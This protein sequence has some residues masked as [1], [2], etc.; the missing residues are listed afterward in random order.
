MVNRTTTI[1]NP[2][3]L[4]GFQGSAWFYPIA[5]ILALLGLG[6][7]VPS[8]ILREGALVALLGVV[9]L[10]LATNLIFSRVPQA[11][12]D[13]TFGDFVAIAL[14]V[15]VLTSV[16]WFRAAIV[17]CRRASEP[18]SCVAG[19]FGKGS[20]QRPVRPGPIP[21]RGLSR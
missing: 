11:N 16:Y 13:R 3:R 19:R 8:A 14:V 2:A 6:S 15:V 18:G 21:S 1:W 7:L 5:L 12:P 10:A 20:P 4:L 9:T 17:V